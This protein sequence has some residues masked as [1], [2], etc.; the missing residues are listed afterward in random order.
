M[1]MISEEEEHEEETF[2]EKLVASEPSLGYILREMPHLEADHGAIADL[3][4]QGRLVV[5]TDGGDD[6]D[7][8]IVCAVILASDDML[9]YHIS[10]HEIYGEPKD[11]GRAEMMGF[12]AALIYLCQII[13][14]H[15]LLEDTPVTIYCDSAET[16]KFVNQRWIGETPKWAD[17]QNIELKRTICD[18]M[19]TFGKGIR[20]EHVRGHQ[21]RTTQFEDLSL[22]AKLNVLCD[23]EC[24]RLLKGVED[25]S[26]QDSARKMMMSAGACLAVQGRPIT[27][28]IREELLKRKYKKRVSAH[29]G[30]TK[31]K[32]DRIDWVS[33]CRAVGLERSPAL[34]G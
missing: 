31:N 21:D 29:L 1:E 10:G 14:W 9:E 8:R 16:V 15:G 22:P 2:L 20:V 23:R 28:P 5:G 34:K 25:R 33:H 26:I 30:I 27:G 32:F 18:L 17:V 4:I 3:M 6:Q 12:T 7:G 13:K 11:S 19:G 24:E